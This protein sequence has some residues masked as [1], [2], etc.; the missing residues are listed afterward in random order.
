MDTELRSLDLSKEYTLEEFKA[1]LDEKA[2]GL[3]NP[4]VYADSDT[5]FV[6][7]TKKID[8]VADL[9]KALD[10]YPDS[11]EVRTV[12]DGAGNYFF[13]SIALKQGT[14]ARRN[15][16]VL[17]LTTAVEDGQVWLESIK[18]LVDMPKSA[19]DGIKEKIDAS[20]R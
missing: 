13:P 20:S 15:Y 16:P 18:S 17:I 3:V 10:A 19:P 5:L 11:M 2:K 9:K 4:T 12:F 7:G 1:H 8:T 6:C 14:H